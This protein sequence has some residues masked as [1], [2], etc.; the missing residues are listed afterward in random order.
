MLKGISTN[1]RSSVR[2]NIALKLF[3]M[4]CQGKYSLLHLFFILYLFVTVLGTDN[5]YEQVSGYVQDSDYV[6][7]NSFYYN[8]HSQRVKISRNYESIGSKDNQLTQHG[9]T[10]QS[11]NDNPY[12]VFSRRLVNMIILKSN[13]KLNG[14]IA[15]GKLVLEATVEELEL[16]KF[17]GEGKLSIRQI[18]DI[19][20]NVIRS[21]EISFFDEALNFTDKISIYLYQ[22]RIIFGYILVV[23]FTIIVT[24]KVQWT[25]FRILLLL[26]T[27]IVI[28]SFMLTWWELL[29]EADI[30]LQAQRSIYNTMPDECR[31]DKISFLKSV[32]LFLGI[33]KGDCFRYYEAVMTDTVLKVTPLH[34]ISHMFSKFLFYPLSI[35]SHY[36]SDFVEGMTKDLPFPFNNIAK[37]MLVIFMP[38]LLG[39]LLIVYFGGSTGLKIG[40]LFHLYL[41]SSKTE[42]P[43]IKTENVNRQ[44][45]EVIKTDLAELK[46]NISANTN[47]LGL[48]RQNS[49]KQ[50]KT[51]TQTEV[52]PRKVEKQED[53][54]TNSDEFSEE[55]EHEN[56]LR[57]CLEEEIKEKTTPSVI[58]DISKNETSKKENES[59]ESVKLLRNKSS[60]D[61]ESKND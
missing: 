5:I 54:I 14:D 18:D 38:T 55:K 28:V 12:E 53:T 51:E 57:I 52:V 24:F 32:L 29:Q 30:K 22:Y 19:L 42:N 39:A 13:F 26:F 43:E 33:R 61:V 37:L 50:I 46:T 31:Q 44:A 56:I 6:D 16:L 35:A 23:L 40:P 1:F 2:R 36:L 60:L 7:P 15:L 21:P 48:P 58:S 59:V 25:G 49:M 9:A 41:H 34:V 11:C 10:Y 8:R 17:Y 4:K 47:S 20:T 27:V 3:I 45:I